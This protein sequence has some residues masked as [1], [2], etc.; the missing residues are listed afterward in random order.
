M[1]FNHGSRDVTTNA[2]SRPPFLSSSLFLLLMTSCFIFQQPHVAYSSMPTNPATTTLTYPHHRT[3]HSHYP[4]P[5]PQQCSCSHI[6]INCHDREFSDIEVLNITVLQLITVNISKLSITTFK[7]ATSLLNITWQNSSIH[8]IEP[9]T[10]SNLKNLQTLDLSRNKLQAMHWKTFHPLLELKLLNLSYNM[11]HD[12]PENIFEGLEKLEEL[13]LSFNQLH[14]IPFQMFAS[15][16]HLQLL[17]LSYNTIALLPDESFLPNHNIINLFLQGN[18]LTDLSSNSFAGLTN[19]K[20][21]D[22]SNNSLQILPSK[23][24]GGLKN[25][26]YLHLGRNFITKL[27]DNS[28]QGLNKLSW[29]NLSDNP[30][31]ILPVKLL[32]FC[33][34]LETLIITH[35]QIDILQDSSFRGLSKLKSLVINNNEH[36]REIYDYSLIHCPNLEYIDFSGNNLTKLPQSLS[37]L[38]KIKNLKLGNNPWSCDC[39]M[40]WFLKWRKN[41]SVT[42]DELQCASPPYANGKHNNMLLTL[43][44]LNCKDTQLVNTTPPLLYELGTD[45]LLEC[46]FTGSPSPSITWVTPTNLAFHWSPS[47][48]SLN[49]FSKH[50]NAH[51][52]NLTLISSDD[53]AR[54]KVLEN[55]TL[56]IQNVLRSDCGVYTC[57]ASNPTGNVTAYVTLNVDPITIYRIKIVSI[58]VGAASAL[59]F[60]FAT[61][62][63][64]LVAYLYHRFG[65][66]SKCC[67]CCRN[68]RVSPRAR[69]IYQMLDNIEQYKTQQLERLREN[70]TQQVH[71]I[72]DNCAQQVEWIQSSYQGQ[73]KHLRDIRDYGTNHL[74]A[75][76]D[77]YYDQVRRVRDYSTSQLNWV[78]ENYVFQR[79]RIRKFSAHQV[80]R[81]RESY[82]Y[83]QQTLNKLLENLPSFYLENCRSGSCGRTDS[84]VFDPSDLTSMDVYV[85]AKINK[86]IASLDETNTSEDTQS[87]LSLYYTP[88]ELSESP[89]L[90]PGTFINDLAIHVKC[91][92]I[93]LHVS[94]YPR[95]R[96]LKTSIMFSV[97]AEKRNLI[98]STKEFNW[99]N[100]RIGIILHD[101]DV[102]VYADENNGSGFIA[103]NS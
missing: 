31:Q 89:H 4:P 27:S 54:F 79:N 76:R 13:S 39:R 24:F 62:L 5:C 98:E 46:S 45:A 8:Q 65:W 94:L 101:A 68:D 67:C 56:Y 26:R 11:L 60:L 1:K 83:Q 95:C 100:R 55:G 14:V 34:N 30:M 6:A 17:D 33:S 21:L 75:L 12:L 28:L 70:Y 69:Q 96:T 57:F 32:I 78:R 90:S 93:Q 23:L 77:Q 91:L 10:F 25:L 7:N 74:T 81:F 97:Y 61:L 99:K 73:V 2:S 53:S 50:P 64:Q 40:L 66:M 36:L 9:D 41:I 35:T 59:A 63:V 84:V 44:G 16:K 92:K 103:E 71:R 29:L 38:T 82:K 88:S 18:S 22:I 47:P 48:T 52:S 72:K 58:L 102:V 87:H 43:R 80:L 19:L 49:E 3:R 86:V 85:K 15:I 20:T 37:T 42:H 51:Y